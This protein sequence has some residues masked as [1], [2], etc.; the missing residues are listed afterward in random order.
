MGIVIN[1]NSTDDVDV[2][3]TSKREPQ[4]GGALEKNFID[5][6]SLSKPKKDKLLHY[7]GREAVNFFQFD[8]FT[9]VEP[10]DGIVRP[11]DDGDCLFSG[12][13]TELMTGGVS[14]RVLIVPGT[15]Q[16]TAARALKKILDWIERDADALYP[17]KV[18][19]MTD[20]PF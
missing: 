2:V 20:I 18:H 4:Q 9:G 10:G 8:A 1:I 6:M 15:T 14:V 17:N 11:D 3:R 12:V 16:K 7:A 19:G 5:L 13:T